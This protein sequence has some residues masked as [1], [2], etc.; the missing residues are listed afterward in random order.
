MATTFIVENLTPDGPLGLTGPPAYE[1][2]QLDVAD[3]LVDVPDHA[4]A[5]FLTAFPTAVEADLV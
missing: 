1:L 5:A 4:L 3:G 2:V